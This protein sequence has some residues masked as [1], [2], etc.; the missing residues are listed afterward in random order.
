MEVSEF[1]DRAAPAGAGPLTVAVGHA[2]K[3]V[4]E[5]LAATLVRM[6]GCAVKF[7]DGTGLTRSANDPPAQLIFGDA[8]L[9]SRLRKEARTSPAS[10]TL[11]KAKFVLVS[12]GDAAHT[13]AGARDVDE[14]LSLDCQE[15]ELFAL[16][17]RLMD[18]AVT[19][20]TRRRPLG[21]MAPGALR[22]VREYIDAHL[23]EK[24]QR[25][26]L[27]KVAGLSSR[28]F[29]RAFKQSTGQTPYQFVIGRRVA[30]ATELLAK[31]SR[32]LADVALE[33]G[34]A[35]QSHFSRTFAG[36]TGETPSACR[37]R[38]RG[39]ENDVRDVDAEGLFVRR[40]DSASGRS[41]SAIGFRG[42]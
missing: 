5:G 34:F 6:P 8:T 16:V 42:P 13:C 15:E 25:E 28:Y 29:A 1:I 7:W 26:D 4:A 33:A 35:D 14:C 39:G 18:T 37:R 11:M 17:Q 23:T 32:A 22:R 27:A 20:P 9:L 21:G 41:L 30:A 38:H 3:L 40:R 2:S 12:N 24:I 10:G 19:R 31:T 36:V